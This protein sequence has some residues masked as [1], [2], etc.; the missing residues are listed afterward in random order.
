MF[1]GK[2]LGVD[3]QT[4][5]KGLTPFKKAKVVDTQTDGLTDVQTTSPSKQISSRDYIL[6]V[7]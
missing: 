1:D 2:S 5:T 4:E 3:R 6:Y 7:L